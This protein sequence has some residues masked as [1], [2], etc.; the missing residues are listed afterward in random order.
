MYRYTIPAGPPSN[1]EYIG[2]NN[3]WRYQEIKKRWALLVAAYCH[4]RPPAPLERSKV[5]VTYYFPD[6]RRRDPD[7]YAPK[8]ILDGMVR[9]GIILDDSFRNID[10]SL[11]AEFGSKGAKTEIIVEEINAN[12]LQPL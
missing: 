4:P 2:R 1:N 11:C 7:N 6:K 8:M 3:R 10:L 5:L 9:C 12:D